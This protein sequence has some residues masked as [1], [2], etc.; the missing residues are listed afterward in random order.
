MSMLKRQ[1]YYFGIYLLRSSA[2][3]SCCHDLFYYEVFHIVVSIINIPS[4]NYDYM[5]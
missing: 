3:E 1:S 2:D 4:P 5:Y